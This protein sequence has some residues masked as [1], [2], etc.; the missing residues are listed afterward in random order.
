MSNSCD[1]SGYLKKK[2]AINRA[3]KKRWFEL[4]SQRLFYYKSHKK[5]K[6]PQGVILLKNC[7]VE[8]IKKNMLKISGKHLKRTFELAAPKEQERDKWIQELNNAINFKKNNGTTNTTSSSSSSSSSTS[9]TTSK[10]KDETDPDLVP[11]STEEQ[12]IGNGKIGVKDF[13]LLCVLG[14]GAFGKVIK[15]RK[16]DDKKSI[17]NEDFSKRY[18]D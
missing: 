5:Q 2:G 7:T 18:V 4:V 3:F 16:K 13:E 1:F 11:S 17:C 6:A 10:K 15:V 14:R 12:L 9:T 8:P